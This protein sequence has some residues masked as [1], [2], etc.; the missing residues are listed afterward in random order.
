MGTMYYT[1]TDGQFTVSSQLNIETHRVEIV[2]VHNNPLSVAM[3]GM[4]HITSD[5]LNVSRSDENS[6]RCR[7]IE[8][9]EYRYQAKYGVIIVDGVPAKS[10]TQE[11][12]DEERVVYQHTRPELWESLEKLQ[13]KANATLTKVKDIG[14][15]ITINLPSEP[16]SPLAV[17]KSLMVK[18]GGRACLNESILDARN[19]RYD[20]TKE[21][22]NANLTSWFVFELTEDSHGE[23]LVDGIP[24][25]ET[26]VTQDQIANGS[27]CYRN[28]GDESPVDPLDFSV[29]IRDSGKFL[30]E[31]VT[32]LV[33]DIFVTLINDESP[34]VTSSSL[35]VPIVEGFSAHIDNESLLI[36]DEDN[37]ASDLIYTI[38]NVPSGGQLWWSNH[39]LQE[40]DNF[41][42]AIVDDGA[43][44]FQALGVGEWTT[45]LSFTDGKY[46][47]QT[48]FTVTMAEHKV[49]LED[50]E[51]LRYSQNEKGTQLTPK[52]IIIQTNGNP[53]ETMYYVI[54]E[55]RN[56]YL[57]GLNDQ[58]GFSQIDLKAGNVC[59][60]PTD[61]NSHSDSFTLNITN[62]EAITEEPN[63]TIQVRVDVWGQVKQDV[64]LDFDS[65][66]ESSVPLPKNLLKLNDLQLHIQR[67][68]CIKII[69]EPKLGFLEVKIPSSVRSQ[70]SASREFYYNYLD[71]NWVYYTWNSS[72]VSTNPQGYVND[73]FSVL[74][75]GYQSIQPGEATIN[76]YI[77]NPPVESSVLSPNT[78]APTSSGRTVDPVSIEDNPSSSGF[79]N[80]A[81]LP[82]L[83]VFVFLLVIIIVV[84]VF[85]ITQQGRIRKRW[86]PRMP[87]HHLAARGQNFLLHATSNMYDLEPTTQAE[88]MTTL[89][90]M[91]D[92][93]SE[94][95]DGRS[96]LSHSPLSRYSPSASHPPSAMYQP[97]EVGQQTYH[98]RHMI[99]RPRSRRSNV[100]VSYSHRLLSEITLDD[101]PR[102]R[103]H[104]FSPPPISHYAT[105]VPVGPMTE[106]SS[107]YE[108]EGESGYLSTLNPSVIADEPVRLV[109]R[110]P[111]V[112][113]VPPLPQE[114]AVEEVP[115]LPQE[116]EETREVEEGDEE[117]FG[118][119]GGEEVG[120]TS[121]NR[122]EDQFMGS[123]TEVCDRFQVESNSNEPRG[124]I[125]QALEQ[126]QLVSAEEPASNCEEPSSHDQAAASP[127]SAEQALHS[128]NGAHA[129]STPPSE[130]EAP[131]ALAGAA[132]SASSSTTQQNTTTSSSDL[133]ALFRTHNP[134]LKHTEYWV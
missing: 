9:V 70:R 122:G 117:G 116:T 8:F 48:Y 34:V 21:T 101:I 22:F 104:T 78:E 2:V 53:N 58:G 23:I 79:P 44:R 12:V 85:C 93:G 97:A 96:P 26:G 106:S 35:M 99:P 43:L 123:N 107:V 114:M 1:V 77:K 68:P 25:P 11:D 103:H 118:E 51:V 120:E 105:P 10:F 33:F 115:P 87:R 113:E 69:Q 28:F 83:G 66:R 109:L 73:S 132:A 88:A 60:I 129:V 89:T 71:Y 134:I 121:E 91:V 16:N 111:K 100:S 3:N 27:V 55:P 133:H 72:I 108:G 94:F 81:L 59:Y 80:Y 76:L 52:H 75:E 40:N 15:N 29:H 63:V 6:T 54:E 5:V 126:L 13:L 65:V 74:V 57:K 37:P 127:S 49:K 124:L 56:G 64:E 41:S 82:I 31:A 47:N 38:L 39:Q 7:L 20:A 61:F 30:R 128:S 98:H 84:T 86:Q 17:H 19:I 45:L 4:V 36:T 92:R 131:P 67:P 110:Q 112:E 42:Q 130:S 32:D 62:R 46:F 95:R 90:E 18:E 102:S 125:Q 24:P 14:L 50:T 119:E